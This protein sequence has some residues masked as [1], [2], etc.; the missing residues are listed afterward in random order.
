MTIESPVQRIHTPLGSGSGGRS[1]MWTP[2]GK[3]SSGIDE[4][5]RPADGDDPFGLCRYTPTHSLFMGLDGADYGFG[6]NIA[7]GG[8]YWTPTPPMGHDMSLSRQGRYASSPAN[9]GGSNAE[10]GGAAPPKLGGQLF[11][12]TGSASSGVGAADG[13]RRG[14]LP[15]GEVK[16]GS[17]GGSRDFSGSF[18]LEQSSSKQGEAA[19]AGGSHH[20]QVEN[21]HPDAHLNSAVA[22]LGFANTFLTAQMLGVWRSLA[23]VPSRLVNTRT[24]EEQLRPPAPPAAADG[25]TGSIGGRGK[26]RGS[27]AMR[28]HLGKAR[29]RQQLPAGL[30]PGR[31]GGGRG[32]R[33]EEGAPAGSSEGTGEDEVG[34][35]GGGDSSKGRGERRAAK[36]K[37]VTWDRVKKMW[38]CA[39][40]DFLSGSMAFDLWV[41]C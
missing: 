3:P 35:R 20:Q 27:A 21:P 31:Q 34:G 40:F 13:G 12:T 26:P 38:R 14:G 17:K 30:Q 24:G 9:T 23:D 18:D 10:A 29:Q 15:H 1:A 32:S 25:A 5:P 6:G 33:A 11:P 28:P 16:G 8:G 7:A 4:G 36:Y 22:L 39:L 37:G 19:A 2:L 41:F